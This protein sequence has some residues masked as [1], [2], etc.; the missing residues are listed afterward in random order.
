MHCGCTRFSSHK[1]D[2]CLNESFIF[3]IAGDTTVFCRI[4]LLF[5]FDKR[6]NRR[7]LSPIRVVAIDL[8]RFDFP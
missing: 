5:W 7:L 4:A 6:I 1:L 2:R 3:F 8:F